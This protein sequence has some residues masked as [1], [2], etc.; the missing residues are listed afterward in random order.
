MSAI[1]NKLYFKDKQIC[2]Y[3]GSQA[4]YN[5]KANRE[6]YFCKDCYHKKLELTYRTAQ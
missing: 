3:C 1:I 6:F 4:T 2:H 5:L